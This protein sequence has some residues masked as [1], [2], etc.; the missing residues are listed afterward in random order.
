[1]KHGDFDRNIINFQPFCFE[2]QYWSE[3]VSFRVETSN[4]VLENTCCF[5]SVA[6]TKD[7]HKR[8]FCFL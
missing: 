8:Q 5:L 6:E 4:S 2:R 7:D 1:M 3:K